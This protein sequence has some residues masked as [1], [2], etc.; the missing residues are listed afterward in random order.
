MFLIKSKKLKVKSKDV[1]EKRYQKV[2]SQSKKFSTELTGSW[3]KVRWE[4]VNDDDDDDDV[5]TARSR[6]SDPALTHIVI[7]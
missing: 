4:K 1:I 6:A 7:T 3:P 2:Q 5:M